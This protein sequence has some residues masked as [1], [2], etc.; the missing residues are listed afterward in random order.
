MNIVFWLLALLLLVAVWFGLY[1]LYKPIGNFLV[2]TY[3][4]AIE[5]MKDEEEKEN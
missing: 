4:D 2:E 1:S 5:N 3:N